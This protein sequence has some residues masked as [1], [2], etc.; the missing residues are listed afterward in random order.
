M[1]GR[2]RA[3]ALALVSR[4]AAAVV[5]PSPSRV[6]TPIRAAIS[7]AD[8]KRG[9]SRAISCLDPTDAPATILHRF[10]LSLRSSLFYSHA[11]YHLEPPVYFALIVPFRAFTSSQCISYPTHITLSRIRHR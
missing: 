4:P 3:G 5:A 8:I 11:C 10:G 2:A 6:R 7:Q 1:E 9:G